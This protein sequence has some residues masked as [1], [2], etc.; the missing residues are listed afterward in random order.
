MRLHGTPRVTVLVGGERAR[1]LWH[2]WGA[3]AG[4][5]GTLLEG[6][7]DVRIS[8]A[9]AR[10]VAEPAQPIAVLADPVVVHRWRRGR[11]D[12][13]AAMA[14]E[15]WLVVPDDDGAPEELVGTV[16]SS[17][18]RGPGGSRGAMDADPVRGP[19]GS[20]GTAE[21]SAPEAGRGDESRRPERGRGTSARA[22]AVAAG[23]ARPVNLDAR[24]AAEAT[25]YE[26]LEA[27]PA[28]TGRFQLN[29]SLSVRFGPQ[30]AE[31]DLL[32]RGDRIAIEIDGVH[33]FADPDC[34]RRDRRKDLLLQT[35]GFV[36]VRLL[37]ED[38]MRDVRSAVNAVCQALAYRLAEHGR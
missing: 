22:G 34:Y 28:T 16:E 23:R 13:L 8:E 32:S 4:M 21:A 38:V 30:A 9:V 10:A 27:T 18:V 14:D 25:L 31:I 24:S 33:H 19:G 29:E 11:M 26:A 35:H 15:G 3:L 6:E 20:R 17:P 2:A 7:F 1:S 36:V 12:R 5:A 37:A